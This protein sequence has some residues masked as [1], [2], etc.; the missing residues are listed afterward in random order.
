MIAQKECEWIRFGRIRKNFFFNNRIERFGVKTTDSDQTLFELLT[1]RWKTSQSDVISDNI[2]F[3]EGDD[4]MINF[5][6]LW[7]I[8]VE[9]E[10]KWFPTWSLVTNKRKFEKRGGRN[11]AERMRNKS[12]RFLYE[13]QWKN[14]DDWKRMALRWRL[15]YRNFCD[16]W[17]F[18]S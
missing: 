9:Y 5:W 12:F 4:E 6:R 11:F 16:D 2:G 13:T 7:R 14:D 3:L 8:R 17:L 18:S 1:S 15:D 10:R